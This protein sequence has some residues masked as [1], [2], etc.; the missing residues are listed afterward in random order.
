[1]VPVVMVVDD[2]LTGARFPAVC[3]TRR[4]SG[5]Y[6]QGRRRCTAADHRCGTPDVMLVD[7]EM[8][9]HGFGFS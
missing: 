2:S 3:W 8:R 6:C 9:M 1:M 7:I 4:L 5:D